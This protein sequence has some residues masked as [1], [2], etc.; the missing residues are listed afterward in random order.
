MINRIVTFSIFV[1]IYVVLFNTLIAQTNVQKSIQDLIKEKTRYTPEQIE[2]AIKIRK[3][4]QELIREKTRFTPQQI[5]NALE[6][7]TIETQN[8]FGTS[9]LNPEQISSINEVI[10]SDDISSESELHAAINPKDSSNLVVSPI[11]TSQ[12][13]FEGLYC[14]IYYSKDFGKTWKKSS[15]QTKPKDATALVIGGGDPMFAFNADGKLYLSWINLYIK[16]FK[17]D[18]LYEEM[19]WAFSVDGG[20]T[21]Q[22]EANGFIGKTIIEG[23]NQTEFF[24][25]QW[26]MVDQ[27]NSQFRGNLYAGIFHPNGLDGRIG[28]RRKEASAKDF[29][30]ETVRPVGNDYSLNQFTSLDIDL[31]G[32][33]HLTFFGDK[34]SNPLHPALYHSISID[35]G[36]TLQQE[37][38]ISEV[39][40]PR[41]SEGQEQDSIIGVQ[42]TR[43]YPCPH[44]VIDKSLSSS[45]KGNCYMVW[46]ANGI[47]KKEGNGL[48]IYFCISTD[49]G[50]TWSTPKI[51]NDDIKGVV[52]EQYYP[53]ITVNERGVICIAWYDRRNDKLNLNTDYFMTFSFDGGKSFVENFVVSQKPTDFSTV[54]LI[55]NGFGVGEYNE[56]LSTANYAIPFWADA[57]N[58]DGN[59]N[60]YSAFVPISTTTNGVEQIT[61][62]SQD[63][64]LYDASPNPSKGVTTIKYTLNKPSKIKLE[65]TDLFGKS[66]MTLYNSKEVGEGEY[67]IE[68]NTSDISSGSYF[69][70]LTTDFGYAIKKLIVIK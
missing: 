54:G 47:T 68:V 36:K 37:T 3:Q 61:S 16:N 58:N 30:Q 38:K 44:F 14:P 34:S 45:Y 49:N 59:M 51:I 31:Q 1:L 69:Y 70:K 56:I 62:L 43:L 40:L 28:I 13:P 48:D 65:L 39:Q 6:K 17:L 66:M 18:T 52:K 9:K 21:W 27:T 53:S 41:F 24:D 63:Y 5:Q 19:S 67:S 46:T 35:G 60:V 42:Q 29:V 22:R 32:G 23:Q 4:V 57:R 25:K 2:C 8:N 33:V 11:K 26:M 64:Q 7:R 20:V 10:V 55:N 12:N 50:N 15:F